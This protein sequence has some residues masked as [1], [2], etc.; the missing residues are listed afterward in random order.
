MEINA[1]SHALRRARKLFM[2]APFASDVIVPHKKP[3]QF[4]NQL[5]KMKLHYQGLRYK[6]NVKLTANY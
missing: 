1:L 6:R 3:G 5:K 2:M 4:R